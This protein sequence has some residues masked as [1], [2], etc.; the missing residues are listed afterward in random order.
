MPYID[1]VNVDGETYALEP[2]MDEVI[3][4]SSNSPVT[5][6]AVY[7][8]VDGIA[9][10]VSEV[11]Q[12]KLLSA[13][14][15]FFGT[16]LTTVTAVLQAIADYFTSVPTKHS[17]RFYTAGGAYADKATVPEANSTKNFTAG[18]AYS[19]KATAPEA[20]STKNYTAGGAYADKTDTPEFGSNKCI[21]SQGAYAYRTDT[22]NA[23]DTRAFTA[24]GAYTY[25]A[26]CTTCSSWIKK[27]FAPKSYEEL[28]H[29]GYFVD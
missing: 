18:G 17:N 1:R 9:G 24:G 14:L 5:S 26:D 3:K 12:P 19:D 22:A 25:F 21:T 28:S 23:S 15:D 6:G 16:I 13:P 27:I 2:V 10:N 20:N 8:Y 29:S 7:D 11:M 4:D